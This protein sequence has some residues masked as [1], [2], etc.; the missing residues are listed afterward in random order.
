VRRRPSCARA[1]E[2]ATLLRRR[3][4]HLPET[5]AG[6][7]THGASMMWLSRQHEPSAAE[8]AETR[9]QRGE[10]GSLALASGARRRCI[11]AGIQHPR[12]WAADLF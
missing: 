3:A 1:G 7:D 12:V 5:V 6:V 11:A 2:R 4:R 10:S 8:L 9:R